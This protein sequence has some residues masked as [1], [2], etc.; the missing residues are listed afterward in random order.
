MREDDIF[1]YRRP[2]LFERFLAFEDGIT[3]PKVYKIN[4]HPIGTSK[5]PK[6]I[7]IGGK[8]AYIWKPSLE[9]LKDGMK[10]EEEN[11]FV[12]VDVSIEELDT[13]EVVKNK[14]LSSLKIEENL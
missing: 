1:E 8:I 10:T 7:N 2:T 12:G 11:G 3:L 5:N 14:I 9:E 6:K 4:K 13:P